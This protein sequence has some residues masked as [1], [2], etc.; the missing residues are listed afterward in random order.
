M[1]ATSLFMRNSRERKE[2]KDLDALAQIRNFNSE[3]VNDNYKK[4][5]KELLEKAKDDFKY[6]WD[7]VKMVSFI[8]LINFNI[9]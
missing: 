9:K 5:I 4:F 8:Y 7:N 2:I 1:L 6:N 3:F